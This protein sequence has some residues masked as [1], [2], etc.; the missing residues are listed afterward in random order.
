MKDWKLKFKGNWNELKGKIKQV[1]GKLNDD[2][3]YD[4]G[5]DCEFV[6]RLQQ[7]LEENK[8]EAINWWIEGI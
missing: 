6:G 5:K 3:K 8:N 4:E 7:R 1:Y 2:L